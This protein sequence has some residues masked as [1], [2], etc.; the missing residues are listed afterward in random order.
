VILTGDEAKQLAGGAPNVFYAGKAAMMY[1]CCPHGLRELTFRW[2]LAVVPY[3]GPGALI[4]GRIWPH[5]LHVAKN[6]P[7]D[8]MKAIWTLFKWHMARPEQGGLHPPANSHIVAPYKDAR[9]SDI[10]LKE[11]ES[12]TRGVSGKAHLVMAQNAYPSACGMLKYEEYN[13]MWDRVKGDW[14][15]VEANQI[16]VRDWSS[17]AQ[18]AIED[19]KMGSKV[20]S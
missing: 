13:D 10:A 9:Y 6:I 15:K 20:I 5:A 8:A 7:D 3:S 1:T 11:F 19:V 16:S 12:I 17:L 4:S 2:G 14:D 18:K